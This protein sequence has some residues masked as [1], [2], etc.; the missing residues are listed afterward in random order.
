VAVA[1]RRLARAYAAAFGLALHELPFR[2]D[3]IRLLA[4]RRPH[5]DPGALWLLDRVKQAIDSSAE[6]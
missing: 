2:R 4:V 5:A 3:P 1:P 6:A